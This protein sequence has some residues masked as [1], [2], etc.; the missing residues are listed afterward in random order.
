MPT[1]SRPPDVDPPSVDAF[2]KSVLRSGLLDRDQLQAAIID[3]ASDR[4]EDPW[5]IAEHL[6]RKGK[7]SRFQANKLLKGTA[8]GL[9]LGNYQILAPLGKGGMGT[10]YMARDQRSGRLLALKV[11]PPHRARSEDRTLARFQRE[12]ELSR[13]VAHPHIALTYETGQYKGVYFIAMEYIPG[14]S[15]YRVV[16]DVGPL[17]TPRVAHLGLEVASALEHAH[18]QGLIHRDLK[19]SNI[20]VTPHHHAKV[21]DLGLAIM[22]GETGEST[23]LGGQGYIVGSMDYISPEQTLDPSKVDARADIY[24]LGCTLFFALTGQPPFPGGTSAEKIQ[25]H[26]SFLPPQLSHLRP[27]VPMDFADVIHRMMAKQP[28]LRLPNARAVVEALRPWALTQ[29]LQPLDRPDDSEF[30]LAIAALQTADTTT[31][32]GPTE[33]PPIDDSEVVAPRLEAADKAPAA[34]NSDNPPFHERRRRQAELQFLLIVGG[35]AVGVLV[36]G[37][38]VLSCLLSWLFGHG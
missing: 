5:A 22:A 4:R 19:P 25:K 2:F 33:L 8:K 31:D 11:L 37:A 28:E 10:V 30:R 32:F 9:I 36:L 16:A 17:N 21:L 6:I 14:K 38:L 34:L 20:M 27:D 26:R 13:R 7:L 23:I 29:V 12:M 35:V 3:I 18:Q 15:L 24:G 1:S